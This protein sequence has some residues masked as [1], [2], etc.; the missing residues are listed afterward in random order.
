MSREK[1][2]EEYKQFMAKVCTAAH[3]ETDELSKSL[4]VSKS[5]A[6]GLYIIVMLD[7]LSSA[8]FPTNDA[9]SDV[10]ASNTDLASGKTEKKS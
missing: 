1:E 10:A 7:K 4:D 3:D 8:I 5:E 2:Y 6:I 9:T